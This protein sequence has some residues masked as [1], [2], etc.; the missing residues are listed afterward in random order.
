M[1]SSTSYVNILGSSTVGAA[2]IVY[3]E[4]LGPIG[5]YSLRCTG[6]ESRITDCQYS[7]PTSACSHRYDGG[8]RCHARTG[9]GKKTIQIQVI[10]NHYQIAMMET[11]DWKEA[12][13]HCKVV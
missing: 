11:F 10:V 6:N 12:M 5:L 4:G 13:T 9:M 1:S 7:T 3:G 8:V 2:N